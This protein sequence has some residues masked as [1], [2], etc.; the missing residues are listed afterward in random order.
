MALSSNVWT[1]NVADST[2]GSLPTQLITQKSTCC[3]LHPFVLSSPHTICRVL[4][5]TVRDKGLCPCPRCLVRKVDIDKVGQ[6]R[7]SRD[8]ITK[9]RTYLGDTIRTARRFIYDLGFN[10]DSAAV[11]QVLKPQS[12]VPTL[13]RVRLT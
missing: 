11:E 5:A 7:D 4:L 13:V 6:K 1:A 8:R 9:A 10:I 12:L 2:H 3:R